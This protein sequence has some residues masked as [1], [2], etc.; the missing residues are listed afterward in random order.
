MNLATVRRDRLL[1]MFARGRHHLPLTEALR[2]GLICAAPAVLAAVLHQPLLCWSAIA[3]FWTCLSDEAGGSTAKRIA[4]GVLFGALGAL[5]SGCVIALGEVL[6]LAIAMTG[7][8]AYAGA[9]AR[10]QG[11]APG[12]R[13]LLIATACAVS[14]S[15]P[16]R[17]L[18]A[19]M[20]YAACFM[21][22]SAWAVLCTVGLWQTSPSRRA[23]RATF[24]YLYAVGSFVHRLADTAGGEPAPSVRGRAELRTRLDAM[25]RAV[26]LASPRVDRACALWRSKGERSIALLAGLESLLTGK[27]SPVRRESARRLATPLRALAALVDAYADAVRRGA[28]TDAGGASGRH[29]RLSAEIRAGIDRVSAPELPDAERG[30]LRACM[31][32]VVRLVDLAEAP[33]AADDAARGGQRA[34]TGR[35]GGRWRQVAASVVGQVRARGQVARYALRLSV[36]AMIAVTLARLSPAG[37]GYWLALTTMFVVQPT[38]SQTVKVSSLRLGGTVLGAI[39]ASVLALL[40]HNPVLLALT[41]VPLAT[42][43]L[44]ARALSYVSYILF[45]TPHFILVAHL[46]APDGPPW[47]LAVSRVGN[48]VAG[49]LIGVLVS[50]VAWPEWERHKLASAATRAISA[51]STYLDAILGG[52]AFGRNMDEQ[53]VAAVRRDACIAIDDLDA[54]IA[55]M[56]LETLLSN[57]RMSHASV[58]V[59]RLRHVVG[60]V[61]PLECAA[62]GLAGAD[63]ARLAEVAGWC[64][65]VMNGQRDVGQGIA[66]LAPSADASPEPAFT[67]RHFEQQAMESAAVIGAIRSHLV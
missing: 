28:E 1:R 62:D 60:V 55:A 9:L 59:S 4:Q 24:A 8:V 13:G 14:A 51:V 40:F 29:A 18:P 36:A 33:A 26:A 49:A 43:T 48:S 47:A 25:S 42:G 19:G 3:A 58:L 7:A 63:R 56:R 52:D 37:Q 53:A 23:R 21:G 30:W 17:G 5:A 15:F 39:L 35:P 44:A 20:Q 6:W 27:T 34:A 2:G 11:A 12:L 32:L 45:L 64:V 38:V 46:G 61:S 41:I 50:L 16:V 10:T 67:V 31:T 57:H 54:V 22:G 66:S 65:A